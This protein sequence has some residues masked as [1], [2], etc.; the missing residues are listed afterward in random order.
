VTTIHVFPVWAGMTVEEA[1]D[2]QETMGRVVEYRWWWRFTR[3]R[4]EWAIVKVDDAG[5]KTIITDDS[6]AV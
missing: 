4:P 5:V 3:P 1:F 6:D 2:E